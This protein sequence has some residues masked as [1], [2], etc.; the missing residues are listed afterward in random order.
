[1]NLFRKNRIAN[2]LGSNILPIED[3][4]ETNYRQCGIGWWSL[5]GSIPYLNPQN[6]SLGQ[7]KLVVVVLDGNYS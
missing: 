2:V 4:T 1:M 3:R 6:R 5:S 7:L